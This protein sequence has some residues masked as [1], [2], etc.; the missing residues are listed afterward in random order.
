MA[1]REFTA[2]AEYRLRQDL[3]IRKKSNGVMTDFFRKGTVL[4]VRKVEAD[5]EQLWFEG[6]S[7]PLAMDVLA[8]L[9][10]PA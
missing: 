8:R 7:E 1:V 2:G 9:V 3:E 6:V 10:D 4:K 5:K